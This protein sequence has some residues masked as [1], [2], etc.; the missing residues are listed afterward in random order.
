MNK[1]N[2]QRQQQKGTNFCYVKVVK[3]RWRPGNP[4]E[5]A[6]SASPDP[7]AGLRGGEGIWEWK[8]RKGEE[9]SE[10][11]K[12]FDEEGKRRRGEGGEGRE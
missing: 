4:A 2:H 10:G 7:L 6:C 9:E 11:E 12:M 1:I 8:R 5:R 3:R